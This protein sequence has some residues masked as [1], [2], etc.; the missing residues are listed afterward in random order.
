MLGLLMPS[1]FDLRASG[2]TATTYAMHKPRGVLSVA[3][4]SSLDPTLTDVMVAAGVKPLSS[5]V[6]RLDVQTSG[7]L[8]ITE[9]AS[10]LRAILYDGAED[11]TSSLP[12]HYHLLLAGRH[13]PDSQKLTSLGS[14]LTFVRARTRVHADAVCVRHIR[15]FHDED[16]YAGFDSID[17]LPTWKTAD[18]GALGRTRAVHATAEGWVTEVELQLH[19]GRH[20]QI[21]RLCARARLPLLHLRRVAIGPISLGEMRPGEVRELSLDEKSRLYESCLPRYLPGFERKER[22]RC[23]E[24]RRN[25]RKELRAQWRKERV[26]S[27]AAMQ[28]P[29]LAVPVGES[30]NGR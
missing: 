4:T 13:L 10:L 12:K 21:R 24:A 8:L 29:S 16:L 28:Q 23:T 11:T 17:R 22:A 5:H 19:Q 2:L 18:S 25:R 1:A 20:H 3:S 30:S 27:G 15:C 26:A 9:D 6:G 7:L 14:P